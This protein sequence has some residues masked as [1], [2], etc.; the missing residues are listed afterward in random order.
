VIAV[1]LS[2]EVLREYHR[3]ELGNKPLIIAIEEPEVH[4]HPQAQRTF[5]DYLKWASKRH[6]TMISTHSPIFVDRAQPENVVLLR[7][8]TQ[9]DEK[10]AKKEGIALKTGTTQA[11]GRDYAENWSGIIEALGLR[12]SDALMAGEVNLL[13]EG[14]TE[15]ILLPAMAERLASMGQQSIDFARVFVVIGEGGDVPHMARLLQGTG[16]PTV[17]LLDNDSEGHRIKK[18]L[19]E[20]DPPVDPVLMLDISTLPPPLNHLKDCEFEDLMNSQVLLEAF[21]EAFDGVPGFEFLPL[22][23]GELEAEQKRL[24]GNGKPFGWVYTVGS[25]IGK[26]T[27]F[28]K[29]HDKRPSDRVVKRVLAEMAA[30][31]V[32]AGRLPVPPFCQKVFTTINGLLEV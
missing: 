24:F 15:A 5:L 1:V 9:R 4:L 8:A 17:V 6:Q 25:L 20:M 19:S 11:I 14:V 32:R 28:A 3:Q 31:Y 13:V 16:N 27:T 26:K 22:D 2:I 29:L 10:L 12:L 18:R 21:N 23:Y 7:R 30:R